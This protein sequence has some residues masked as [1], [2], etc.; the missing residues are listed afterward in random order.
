MHVED[1]CQAIWTILKKGSLGET[2]NVGGALSPGKTGRQ[3]S[4][5]EVVEIICA[6]L[7]EARPE[8]SWA[9]HRGLIRFMADRPGHDKR[10]AINSGK[11]RRELGW[12]PEHTLEDGLRETVKWYLDNGA[13]VDAI[14]RRHGFRKWIEKNY[15]KRGG[16]NGA[17]R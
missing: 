5:L 13:W 7:D 3:F 16:Q 8:A 12:K 2:Y 6:I 14:R 11:I 9:P 15:W 4:N 17:E 10:Y 1:H